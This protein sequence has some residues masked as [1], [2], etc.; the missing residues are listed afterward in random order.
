MACLPSG[1]EVLAFFQTPPHPTPPYPRPHLSVVGS[2]EWH[3]TFWE[4]EIGESP[5]GVSGQQGYPRALSLALS[6][7]EGQVDQDR[8]SQG[9]DTWRRGEIPEAAPP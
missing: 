4:W 8:G 7:K 3:F 2:F 1:R 6:W 9:W 5:E